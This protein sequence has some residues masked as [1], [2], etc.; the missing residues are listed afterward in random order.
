MIMLMVRTRAVMREKKTDGKKEAAEEF[1]TGDE[2]SHLCGHG[3]IQAG[4]EFRD[5]AEI[6]KLAPAAFDELPTPI[7]TDQQEEWRL[8]ERHEREKAVV[9]VN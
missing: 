6:V 5:F 8:Q 9:K 4:K 3:E 7:Q 1:D 2:D